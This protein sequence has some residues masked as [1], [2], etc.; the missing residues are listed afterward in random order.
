M[1]TR[2]T[3]FH[4]F[5]PDKEKM[6]LY[7]HMEDIPPRRAPGDININLMMWMFCGPDMVT[8]IKYGRELRRP[9]V[10]TVRLSGVE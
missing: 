1:Q 6:I 9:M 4:N 8:P 7:D 10:I 2:C 3:V 5:G